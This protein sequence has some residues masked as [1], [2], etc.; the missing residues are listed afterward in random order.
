MKN[1]AVVAVYVVALV[2]GLAR[3]AAARGQEP[4]T[5]AKPAARQEASPGMA[6]LTS[7]WRRAAMPGAEHTKL[8]QLEGIWKCRMTA[9][10]D[11]TDASAQPIENTVF[12]EREMS[13]G[14]RVLTETWA[15]QRFGR[16]YVARRMTGYDTLAGEYWSVSVDN[17]STRVESERGKLAQD[18]RIEFRGEFL[19]PNSGVTPRRALYAFPREGKHEME[20]YQTIGG[21]EYKFLHFRCEKG[22]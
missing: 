5:D 21:K 4:S 15:S 3:P 1:A 13:L 8:A 22:Q 16:P 14:G 2:A 19:D 12:I 17:M 20:W 7:E 9:L 6:R 11:P 18:G 10:P